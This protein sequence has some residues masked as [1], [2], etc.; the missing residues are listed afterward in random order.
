MESIR[1]RAA[2]GAFKHK[3]SDVLMRSNTMYTGMSTHQA[4]YPSPTLGLP[5]FLILIQNLASAQSVVPSRI[6]G[7]AATRNIARDLLWTGME[8]ERMY[9]QTIVDAN[10]SRGVAL[11]QN[12]GLLVAMPPGHPKPIIMLTLGKQPGT[13]MCDANLGLLVGVGTLR[14][15]QKAFLSWAYTIDSGKTFVSAGSTPGSKTVITGLPPLTL[16]GVRVCLTNMT[17]TGPWSEVMT[18]TTIR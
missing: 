7:A 15:T 10:P 18:I 8:T 13:V 14:P 1:L 12:A 3:I 5:A 11:I 6:V 17:G 4:D 2:I 16:V 9:V